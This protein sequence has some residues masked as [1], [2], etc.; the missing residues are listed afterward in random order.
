MLFANQ[1]DVAVLGL[2]NLTAAPK[3][4]RCR[5]GEDT[6]FHRINRDPFNLSRRSYPQRFS[7]TPS[8]CPR[9]V[10]QRRTL[11]AQRDSN[12]SPG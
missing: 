9:G 10:S 1:P 5:R 7:G 2:A 8:V 6:V 12:P 11:H 4:S 3:R